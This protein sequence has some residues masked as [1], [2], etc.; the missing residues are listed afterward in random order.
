MAPWQGSLLL[1][2]FIW[3]CSA[4]FPYIQYFQIQLQIK[5]DKSQGGI[6]RFGEGE[7]NSNTNM[8]NEI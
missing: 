5:F 2:V 4:S 3:F 1:E 6:V 7:P 8:R